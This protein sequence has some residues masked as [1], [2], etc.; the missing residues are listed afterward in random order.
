MRMEHD[1]DPYR[2]GDHRTGIERLVSTAL[3]YLGSRTSEHWL[4]FIA[5]LV[6]G[7]AVG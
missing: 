6:I 3:G 4:M 5:G 1:A 7:L 2:P